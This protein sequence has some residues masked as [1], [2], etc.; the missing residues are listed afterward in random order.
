MRSDEG[1]TIKNVSF[2]TIISGQIMSS[3]PL[4]I[5][6]YPGSYTLHQ[7]STTVSLEISPL[8]TSHLSPE[9]DLRDGCMTP[10]ATSIYC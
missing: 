10:K 7:H 2:Q 3:T 8:C 4:L 1:L 9:G 6:N 5:P